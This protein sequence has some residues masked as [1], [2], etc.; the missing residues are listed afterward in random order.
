MSKLY[1]VIIYTASLS[2]YAIPLLKKLD[3]NGFISHYLFRNHCSLISNTFVKDLSMLGRRL[4]QTI[5]IDNSPGAYML[6]PDNAI[7]IKTWIGDQ[8]DNQLIEFIPLLEI[9][10]SVNDVRRHIRK[11]LNFDGT[12]KNYSTLQ[13]RIKQ[14]RYVPHL[15][16]V[17]QIQSIPNLRIRT[18]TPL[19]S[20]KTKKELSPTN[21]AKSNAIKT[22]RINNDKPEIPNILFID[23]RKCETQS[24]YYFTAVNFCPRIEPRISEPDITCKIVGNSTLRT[25]SPSFFAQEQIINP[26]RQS[27][28]QERLKTADISTKDMIRKM[29]HVGQL[30]KQSGSIMNL[31][32]EKMN[33]SDKIKYD[34]G[35]NHNIY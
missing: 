11:L 26:S 25:S 8:Q 6:Q 4:N 29:R 31:N 24:G 7:P 5:I 18:K 30:I 12:F 19:L 23:K 14:H 13:S 20:N 22:L 9:L 27:V 16:H 35:F 33:D 2:D 15:I 32:K 34:F 17:D 1:E 28:F 10:S 3:P 21:N